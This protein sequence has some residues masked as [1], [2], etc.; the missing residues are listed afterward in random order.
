MYDVVSWLVSFGHWASWRRAVL[1]YV[2]G[3]RVLEIGFGTGELLIEMTAGGYNVIGLDRS[4]AMQHI[5]DRKLKRAGMRVPRV[6]GEVQCMPFSAHT[7]DTIISTFPAEFILDQATLNET[8]RLL[9]LPR[10]VELL[11]GGRLVI[12]GLPAARKNANQK[13]FLE[14]IFAINIQET[15]TLF[16]DMVG[17][18][19]L[20]V[21]VEYPPGHSL[22]NP[23]VI[24]TRA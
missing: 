22:N 2:A 8:A 9:S 23:I 16:V 4:R 5:T 18:A 1:D 7:F 13:T 15:W 24:L 19:G 3:D 20:R 10:D 17:S 11:D 12:V 21:Q 14:K 6:Q